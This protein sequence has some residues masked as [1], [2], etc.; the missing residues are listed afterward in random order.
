MLNAYALSPSLAIIIF[1][2]II[3]FSLSLSA[4]RRFIKSYPYTE[5]SVISRPCRLHK[6]K[7]QINLSTKLLVWIRSK[8][9][10]FAKSVA[11]RIFYK[12]KKERQKEG[13]KIL[14]PS[15]F[16]FLLSNFSPVDWNKRKK[17]MRHFTRTF[18]VSLSGLGSD[19]SVE[20]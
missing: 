2:N 10:C 20:C 17:K 9:E 12:K 5:K 14:F 18:Y 19:N 8:P 15:I 16:F 4:P 7:K 11:W 6:I 3:M 1:F 13:R